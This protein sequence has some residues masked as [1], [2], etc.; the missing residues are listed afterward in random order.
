MLLTRVLT[1]AVLLPIVVAA[2]FLGGPWLA[3]VLA[4]FLLLAYYEFA[5]L[6]GEA[7]LR[8]GPFAL[9]FLLIFVLILDAH[10]A[11]YDLAAPALAFTL[12]LALSWQVLQRGQKAP[13]TLWCISMAGAIYLGWLGRC[14]VLLR[15]LPLGLQWLLLA[16]VTTWIT[17]SGA[18]F[19]GR[20]FGRHKMVPRLSPRKTW[21]G[22]LGGWLIG[23]AGGML[24]GWALG[25]G[26]Q[27]GLMVGLLASTAAPFGDLSVSMFK[28]QVGAKDTGKL[29]PGHGGMWDRL[30]SP[31]FVVPVVYYYALWFGAL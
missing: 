20:A 16:L 26:W 29:L 31:L 3:G 24:V 7:G 1:A 19:V 6:M 27:H 14:V 25:L 12:L 17:D 4:L 13:A 11:S 22:A 28:R 8:R 2:I 18:Y 30:D 10:L 9:G 23:V 5:H 21:E 15:N